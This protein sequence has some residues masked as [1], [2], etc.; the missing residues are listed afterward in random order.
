MPSSLPSLW[1]LQQRWSI[2]CRDEGF[3]RYSRQFVLWLSGSSLF[4]RSGE[5]AQ[6]GRT[7]ND[8]AVP[9]SLCSCAGVVFS[10]LTWINYSNLSGRSLFFIIRHNNLKSTELNAAAIPRKVTAVRFWW[11]QRCPSTH[12]RQTIWSKPPRSGRKPRWFGVVRWW[13]CVW[14]LLRIRAVKVWYL[15]QCDI[16]LRCCCS[17]SYHIFG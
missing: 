3:S 10:Q 16:C 9:S 5:K 2:L 17:P 12:Q 14:S 4:K 7:P 11:Q 13:H 1:S 6:P 15:R 8:E